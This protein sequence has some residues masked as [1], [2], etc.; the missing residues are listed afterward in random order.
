MN[1][2]IIEATVYVLGDNIDTDQMITAEYMKI[3]P[4]TEEG[5]KELGSLAMCGLP[6]P[7][8]PFIDSKKGV[9]LYS[10]IV[11]GKN[12]GCGSSR[13]HAPI[14]LGAS[15]IKAVI[16]ESFARIFYRNCISTGEL[17]PIECKNR[18]CDTVKTGDK[19]IINLKELS[20][21]IPKLNKT[22]SFSDFGDL[23]DVINA[24]GIFN[25]AKEIGMVSLNKT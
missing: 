4:S 25:Y 21:Q 9:S 1:T 14:A 10:V 18:L 12:F 17:L 2:N 22:Y 15:G 20:L 5:Y 11:A 24:G 23:S 16:A 6:D 19:V 7:C 8:L 3:N 13:E